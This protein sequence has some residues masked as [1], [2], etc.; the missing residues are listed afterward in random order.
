MAEVAVAGAG[1]ITVGGVAT[2][3]GVALAT[4]AVEAVTFFIVLE[5]LDYVKDHHQ[6]FS[7]KE[8]SALGKELKEKIQGDLE[9]FVKETG[10]DKL[11]PKKN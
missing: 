3:L 1:A 9:K 6:E 5:V 4:G 10:L 11:E 7:K 8:L 2:A